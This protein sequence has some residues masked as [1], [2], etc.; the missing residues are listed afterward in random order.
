MTLPRNA[1]LSIY[2]SLSISKPLLTRGSPATPTPP[3]PVFPAIPGHTEVVSPQIIVTN[4]RASNAEST[5]LT[6]PPQFDTSLDQPRLGHENKPGPNSTQ[7]QM[8]DDDPQRATRVRTHRK[9]AP[10]RRCR[11][12]AGR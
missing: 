12:S 1:L 6:G 10:R 2:Q 8:Q 9:A 7:A 5:S 11:M 4:E 3:T